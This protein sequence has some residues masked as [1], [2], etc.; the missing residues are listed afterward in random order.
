MKS[1]KKSGVDYCPFGLTFNSYQRE[2][3]VRQKN[4]FN[5]IE[6]EDDL[7]LNIHTGKYRNLDQAIGRWW[8]IDPKANPIETPYAFGSNNPIRYSDFLGDTIRDES[9]KNHKVWGQAYQ[10]WLKSSAGKR[11]VK[12]Y[13]AGGKYGHVSVNLKVGDT[14]GAD[15]TTATYSVDKK[16]G[17]SQ[18][19]T[20]NTVYPGMGE[21]AQ[22]TSEDSYLKFDLTFDENQPETKSALSNLENAE[23]VLHETQHLRINQQTLITNEAI[24]P[25]YYQHRD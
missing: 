6:Y 23:T 15:G 22:G 17:R 8:Q 11:F 4:K 25:N 5:G 16:T 24:N 14:K 2:N 10:T 7:G 18:K 20:S 9:I 12:L 21:V 13:S 3:S 19:L 1:T